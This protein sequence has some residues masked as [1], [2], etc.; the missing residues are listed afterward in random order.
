VRGF[1]KALGYTGTVRSPTY[2]LLEPYPLTDCTVYHLDLYRISDPEELDY[3]GLRDYLT[4]TMICLIEWPQQGGY[5][6]P[7][8]DLEIH[9][10][11]HHSGRC[12][13]LQPCSERGQIIVTQV[14]ALFMRYKDC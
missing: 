13:T 7:V 1:L 8:A 4:T 6:T 12:L 5:L 3:L 2:T 10:A 14:N 11:Y 9:L